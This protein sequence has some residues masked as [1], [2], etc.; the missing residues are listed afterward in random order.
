MSPLIAYIRFI[1]VIQYLLSWI[2]PLNCLSQ[3]SFLVN[4][5]LLQFHQYL[6]I[7]HFI[8]HRKWEL[9]LKG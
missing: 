2:N 7:F 5:F 9:N 3:L 6:R 4:L 8:T 1:E